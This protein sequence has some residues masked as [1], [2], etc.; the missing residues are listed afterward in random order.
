MPSLLQLKHRITAGGSV[1]F[2]M[3]VSII[4][5]GGSVDDVGWSVECGVWNEKAET[6]S[7]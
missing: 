6:L 5:P 2:A 3:L 7:L 4:V 1:G